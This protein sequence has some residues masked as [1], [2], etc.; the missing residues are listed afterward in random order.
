MDL[1]LDGL[2]KLAVAVAG[3]VGAVI[4]A[5]RTGGRGAVGSSTR[6]IEETVAA[7]AADVAEI[8]VAQRRN[9][10]KVGVITAWLAR[11]EVEQHQGR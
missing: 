10:A 11:H 7:I 4:G 8:S 5:W 6:R 9:D 2:A 3:A 1:D